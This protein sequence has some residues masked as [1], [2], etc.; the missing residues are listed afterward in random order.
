MA[1][2]D[3]T[4]IGDRTGDAEALQAFA[5]IF[6]SLDCIFCLFLQRDGGAYDIG[7]LRVFEAYHLGLLTSLVRIETCC[8]TDL[9]GFFDILDAVFVERSEN[10][11]DTAVLTFKFYFSNHSVA[12]L[13]FFTWIN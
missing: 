12:L 1:E 7:P 3:L 9:V 4:V 2:S 11:L 13:L 5:N 6:C 8:V 10:L